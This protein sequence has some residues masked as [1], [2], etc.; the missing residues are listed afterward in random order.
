[1]RV[2]LGIA[3]AAYAGNSL[4]NTL[5]KVQEDKTSWSPYQTHINQL[6]HDASKLCIAGLDIFKGDT[7]ALGH[8]IGD[9]MFHDYEAQK[10]KEVDEATERLSGAL[11]SPP[12]KI[13]K[14]TC[15]PKPTSFGGMFGALGMSEDVNKKPDTIWPAKSGEI[16]HSGKI[17]GIVELNDEEIRKLNS[18]PNYYNQL[19]DK[20]SNDVQAGKL[21]QYLNEDAE[22]EDLGKYLETDSTIEFDTSAFDGYDT[23]TTSLKMGDRVEKGYKLSS[24]YVVLIE[25]DDINQDDP[26][27]AKLKEKHP[28]K[29]T[30]KKMLSAIS[31]GALAATTVFCL[32]V[33]GIG[34]SLPLFTA[35]VSIAKALASCTINAANLFMPFDKGIQKE[36]YFIKDYDVLTKLSEISNALEANDGKR[37]VH[38]F[39]DFKGTLSREEFKGIKSSDS[40]ELSEDKL[41]GILNKAVALGEQANKMHPIHKALKAHLKNF[42]DG[43]TE[44]EMQPLEVLNKSYGDDLPSI[45]KEKVTKPKNSGS[46]GYYYDDMDNP[47]AIGNVGL[48]QE[49]IEKNYEGNQEKKNELTAKIENIKKQ[50]SEYNQ[51]FILA[52]GDI[53]ILE[54]ESVLRDDAKTLLRENKGHYTILTGGTVPDEIQ[55]EYGLK[56]GENYFPKL[57][58]EGKA[59]TAQ[60]LI[61]SDKE[62]QNRKTI[63]MG[64]NDNDNIL[65]IS[66]IT[67]LSVRILEN[68]ET[69]LQDDENLEQVAEAVFDVTMLN[70]EKFKNFCKAAKEVVQTDKK[71][72]W[73]SVAYSYFVE[74]VVDGVIDAVNP[75]PLVSFIARTIYHIASPVA[76]SQVAEHTSKEIYNKHMKDGEPIDPFVSNHMKVISGS[77]LSGIAALTF[78]ANQH[79]GISMARAGFNSLIQCVAVAPAFGL[80]IL[81]D[82]A[83]RNYGGYRK[84]ATDGY[85]KITE[86]YNNATYDNFNLLAKNFRSTVDNTAVKA[87]D[88]LD[89][90]LTSI[91]SFLPTMP[92]WHTRSEEKHGEELTV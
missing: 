85:K 42:Y 74:S 25:P 80:G 62:I 55:K 46:R 51:T 37:N 86:M 84:L 61:D 92:R 39:L 15:C 27:K 82:N 87:K 77:L 83:I 1:M 36:N 28:K 60:K 35:G 24:K 81:G 54:T 89:N 7:E 88:M 58:P 16:S 11:T 26:L 8:F 59:E 13:T 56:E 12:A 20:L 41:F 3:L 32:P 18:D 9:M 75:N 45:D 70:T 79:A 38:Y 53:H 72:I 90:T 5:R 63:F 76:F 17:I 57:S 43:N 10:K 67:D 6:A 64:D 30:P 65:G 2:G 66:N 31:L 22:K 21:A 34:P 40:K 69:D 91:T 78:A 14:H 29:W 23:G 19:T 52:D 49:A 50:K 71:F 33:I 68:L 47:L 73:A 44:D 48:I 4:R